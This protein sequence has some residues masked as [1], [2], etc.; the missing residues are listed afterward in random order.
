MTHSHAS[1]ETGPVAQSKRA[2]RRTTLLLWSLGAVALFLIALISYESTR[3]NLMMPRGGNLAT[4]LG[5]R[6]AVEFALHNN[7]PIMIELNS[8]HREALT[9]RKTARALVK[10]TGRG[11]VG[12]FVPVQPGDYIDTRWG[13]KVYLPTTALPPPRRSIIE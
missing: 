4:Y 9:D 11:D 12:L 7:L 2:S 5:T 8:G 6:Q 3:P 10:L 13:R 1:A